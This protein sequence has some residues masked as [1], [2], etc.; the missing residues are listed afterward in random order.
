MSHAV[1]D[2]RLLALDDVSLDAPVVKP[3]L[4]EETGHKSKVM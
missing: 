3:P 1:S 2:Q 4:P